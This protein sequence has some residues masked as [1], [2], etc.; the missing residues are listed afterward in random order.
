M[1]IESQKVNTL[2]FD[3]VMEAAQNSMFGLEDIGFCLDCGE[4][5][6]GVEQDAMNYPCEACGKSRVFGASEILLA[7]L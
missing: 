1:T 2:D 4:E 7:G 5:H 6:Y 3:T